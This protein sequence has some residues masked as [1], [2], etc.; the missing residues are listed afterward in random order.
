ML[1]GALAGG[2]HLFAGGAAEHHDHT[3]RLQAV[4]ILHRGFRPRGAVGG[5]Q[6]Q[7]TA[8]HAAAGVDL[9]DR[10]QG[11]AHLL[12]A[13]GLV[14]A[15]AWVAEADPQG[16]GGRRGVNGETEQQQ[17]EADESAHGH[18]SL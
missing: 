9:V 6:A 1:A 17:A 18:L 11:A 14:V 2:E 13:L 3:A 7:R 4:D 12:K 15:G 8:E 16:I 10:Q 5:F